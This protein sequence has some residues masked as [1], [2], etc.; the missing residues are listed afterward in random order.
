MRASIH[1]SVRLS[2]KMFR[3]D[4]SRSFAV[5]LGQQLQQHLSGLCLLKSANPASVFLSEHG[6]YFFHCY[7][8]GLQNPARLSCPAEVRNRGGE[9]ASCQKKKNIKYTRKVQC[10]QDVFG[11]SVEGHRGVAPS[12]GELRCG[13][14]FP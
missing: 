2:A 10:V 14:Q 11:L 4:F 7:R 13:F 9:L 5:M 12:Y 3:Q 6:E 8:G 1:P